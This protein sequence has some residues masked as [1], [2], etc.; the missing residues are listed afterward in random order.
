MLEGSFGVSALE[1]GVGAGGGGA[2]EAGDV[3]F[4]ILAAGFG[5]RA[6]L[7]DFIDGGDGAIGSEV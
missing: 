2:T 3:A 7:G 4:H 1:E 5:A 6:V